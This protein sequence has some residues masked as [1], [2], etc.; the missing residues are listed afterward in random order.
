MAGPAERQELANVE[1]QRQE[2]GPARVQEFVNIEH[3]LQMAGPAEMQEFAN[4]ERQRQEAGPARVQEFV[5]IKHQLQMA[6]PA[7]MR[8][9]VHLERQRHKA[10][11]AGTQEF[12]IRPAGMQE[13]ENIVKRE[14]GF[15]RD[16]YVRRGNC[17]SVNRVAETFQ[18]S[19]ASEIWQQ[20]RS[21]GLEG[22][23]EGGVI[24]FGASDSDSDSDGEHD[25]LPRAREEG[26]FYRAI[27][28]DARGRTFVSTSQV[29]VAAS[30]T[31]RRAPER[32][33]LMPDDY[34]PPSPMDMED[35]AIPPSAFPFTGEESFAFDEGHPVDPPRRKQR[36]SDRTMA[37]WLQNRRERYLDELLRLEG[38]GD[39]CSQTKCAGCTAS[40]SDAVFR[41]RD[42]FTEAPFCKSCVVTEHTDNPLHR[43][44]FWNEQNFFETESGTLLKR[45]KAAEEGARRAAEER[46]PDE[47]GLG[48]DG[49]GESE[50]PTAATGKHPR[51][52]FC[53]VD[54]N[55]V[56]EVGLDFCSCA[57]AEDH[58]IQ[59]VRARLYPAT[60]TNPATAATFRVLR[61]FHLLSLEAKCSANYFYNK[62]ARHTNNNGVFQPRRGNGATSRCTS[63]PGGVMLSMELRGLALA[64]GE[65]PPAG[66]LVEERTPRAALY[67]RV[68]L[69]DGREFSHETEGCVD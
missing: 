57:S 7:G 29:A 37:Q 63:V 10:G 60:T 28:T 61:D 8:E 2:A 35:D 44:E 12:H 41:C 65:E 33:L 9:F 51:N 56:H 22:L 62:L 3:Q 26:L 11:P 27:R 5:N 43:V 36:E 13:V 23:V 68:V 31:K 49:E 40:A 67:L 53:I 38:R 64:T 66:W 20:I 52:D 47:D 30:P 50:E 39:H 45:A 46:A 42:C 54:S 24:C 17:I 16:S 32:D 34:E 59:L 21:G 19:P 58:D 55:G 14:Q 1:R 25:E 48:V 4:V 6:G 69:G 18:A 15:V